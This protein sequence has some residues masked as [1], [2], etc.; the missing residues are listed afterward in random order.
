MQ[1]EDEAE[2]SMPNCDESSRLP[3]FDAFAFAV[4]RVGKACFDYKGAGGR[5]L[6]RE[7]E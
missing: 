6:A 2:L 1:C 3:R 4:L 7:A 5:W